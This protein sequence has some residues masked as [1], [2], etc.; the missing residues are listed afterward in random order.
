MTH[1]TH[2]ELAAWL[3]RLSGG[4]WPSSEEAPTGDTPLPEWFRA[5]VLRLEGPE[6]MRRLSNFG[7]IDAADPEAFDV[8]LL[9][10]PIGSMM[11]FSTLETAHTVRYT[12]GASTDE[13]IVIIGVASQ[14]GQ[15]LRSSAGEQMLSIG[16]MGF[17]TSLAAC[18]AE[19]LGPGET[20][21]VVVPAVL[22]GDHRRV[23]AHG[24]GVFPDTALTR[25]TGVAVSRMV[26]EWA[27]VPEPGH[28]AM[29]GTEAALI[30]LVRALFRQLADD[31]QEDRAARIRAEAARI[32]DRHHRDPS[33]GVDQLAAALHISRRQL[34][35]FFA[36]A[37]ES[38]ATLLLRHRLATA[39][40]ELLS[41]PMQD[42]VAVAAAAGFAD[43][44]AL[45]AQ[46]T[47]H[48]GMSPRAFRHAAH[49][50]PPRLAEAM[51]LSGEHDLGSS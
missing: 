19:H 5:G 29:A 34:Y 22:L 50:R 26:Y 33:F 38:V 3:R 18:S 17:L 24:A 46:F 40:E 9:R 2:A 36:G 51:L 45:R 37:D 44:A 11:L 21:G 28:S 4:T 25:A 27:R 35:R 42:L 14:G 15:R 12:R 10:R 39:Q 41:V 31:T 8:A 13:D 16:R 43:A 48:T 23:L 47:R 6:G 49:S 7:S 20:T 1:I 32:I 30:A